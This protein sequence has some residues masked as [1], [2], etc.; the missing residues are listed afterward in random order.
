MVGVVSWKG[1][2]EAR[3]GTELREDNLTLQID[4]CKETVNRGS[5]SKLIFPAPAFLVAR[6]LSFPILARPAPAN[7]GS[8]ELEVEVDSTLAVLTNAR[9]H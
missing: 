3:P 8:P 9:L 2:P 1:E 7:S 4:C 5:S 6:P